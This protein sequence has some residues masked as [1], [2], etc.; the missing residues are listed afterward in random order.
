MLKFKRIKINHIRD[1]WLLNQIFPKCQSMAKINIR[2][3]PNMDNILNSQF[4]ILINNSFMVNL[5]ISSIK[6]L[7]LS[8]LPD[9]NLNINSHISYLT[10]HFSLNYKVAYINNKT[11]I[12][13]NELML[14][15]IIFP[16]YIS[17]FLHF[18]IKIIYK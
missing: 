1:K 17:I 5:T 16:K 4:K 8:L 3:N 14:S 10:K 13:D 2:C 6:I 9:F 7:S 18:I 15:I 11:N 12:L